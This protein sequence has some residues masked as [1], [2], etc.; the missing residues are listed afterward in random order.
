MVFIICLVTGFLIST[1]TGEGLEYMLALVIAITGGSFCW[2]KFV[3]HGQ[4]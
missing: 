3:K 4:F 2:D 1:G